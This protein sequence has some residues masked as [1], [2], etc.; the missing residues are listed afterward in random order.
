MS[1]DIRKAKRKNKIFK[2]KIYFITTMEKN[3]KIN[4]DGISYIFHIAS[5]ASP[6]RFYN[7]PLSVIRA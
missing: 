2:K 3:K 7:K 4:L 5:P 6:S 1:H